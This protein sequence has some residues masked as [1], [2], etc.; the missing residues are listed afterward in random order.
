MRRLFRILS[1]A[2]LGAVALSLVGMQSA[3]A[4]VDDFSFVSMQVDY[5]LDRDPSGRSVLDTTEH[6]IA[7]FPESDQNHGIRRAIPLDYDGHPLDIELRSVTDGAGMPLGYTFEES[8]GFAVITIADDAFVHGQREYVLTY[9]LHNVVLTTGAGQEFYW[10]VNGT[11][12]AQSF[13]I[14]SARLQLGAALQPSAAPSCYLGRTGDALACEQTALSDALVFTG[15]DLGP[16]ETLTINVPFAPDTFVARDN[17]LFATP[18]G[19][20]AV[21]ALGLLAVLAAA[22]WMLRARRWRSHPGSGIVIAEYEAP[23][24]LDAF[25]LAELWGAPRRAPAALV[26]ALAVSGAAQLIGDG[27]SSF[28]LHRLHPAR[29]VG[30]RRMKLQSFSQR[31]QKVIDQLFRAGDRRT[32]GRSDAK[33]AAAFTAARATARS[34]AVESGLRHRP[35]RAL[36]TLLVSVGLLLGVVAAGA[37]LLSLFDARGGIW[38]FVLLVLALAGVIA[39]GVAVAVRPLTERGR[40]LRDQLAGVK[41]F[42]EYT[43]RDRLAMLQGPDTAERGADGQLDLYESL[44]PVAILLGVDEA[45]SARLGDWYT[46]HDREPGWLAHPAGFTAAGLVGAV[47]SVSSWSTSASAS[48]SSGSG[49]SG[50]A[51]GGGGGGGGGGV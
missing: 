51:G 9:R 43:E 35:D 50:F 17:R 37:A 15:R 42:L 4:G 28:E 33:L 10:D 3:R 34:A 7:A 19:V 11:G 16:G 44:L 26:T 39:I 1:V 23:A 20:V 24:G 36:R 49:G 30:R 25:Q 38:P 5:L 27:R 13:G 14:V 48:P 12:W 22:A 2:L 46:E 47:H 31:E 21:S 41:L 29:A 8:D 45:W 6:L 18:S 40:V 32:L